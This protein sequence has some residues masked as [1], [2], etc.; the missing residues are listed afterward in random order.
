MYSH[1]EL[2]TR[3]AAHVPEYQPIEEQPPMSLDRLRL[4]AQARLSCSSHSRLSE[5]KP[6]GD[7]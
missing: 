3:V 1:D 5:G 6:Y 4:L 7:A 2:P